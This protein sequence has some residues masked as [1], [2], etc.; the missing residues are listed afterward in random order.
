MTKKDL[1]DLKK[2]F[3]D[4][5]PHI[6]EY[7]KFLFDIRTKS[8]SFEFL[9]A[10]ESLITLIF[11]TLFQGL[12]LKGEIIFLIP[13]L[14]FFISILFSLANLIPKFISFPWFENVN[15]KQV[16]ETR[17]EKDFYEEGL[18]SIYGVLAHLGEFDKRRNK[19][20][21][22][23]FLAL[24]IAMVLSL[25]SVLV[26][27]NLSI[28]LLLFIPISILSWILIQKGWGKELVL[29]SPALEIEK[30]F[31]KWKEEELNRRPKT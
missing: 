9:L 11:V 10:F 16:F 7:Y 20:F 2:Y 17:K 30:F 27:H 1:E 14:A 22:W 12:I 25:A 6:Y 26:Y 18:R 8:R 29:K 19:I 4:I 24:Y 5:Y 31:D 3:K 23:N 21:F 15:L 28:L 13:L